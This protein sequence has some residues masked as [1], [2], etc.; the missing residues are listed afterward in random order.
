MEPDLAAE[1]EALADREDEED[2]EEDIDKRWFAKAAPLVDHLNA[3]SK[4]VCRHPGFT[5]A[6]DEQMKK[7]KGRS[8]QTHRM[9]NK[10]IKEGFKF[11]ALCDTGT[12]FVFHSN[13]DGRGE[14]GGTLGDTVK[15]LIKSLPRRGEL[16]H[17]IAM[18]NLFT[19]RQV[20]EQSRQLCVA[21]V[22]AARARRGW[23]PKEIKN[24]TD[25]RFNTLCLLK[26]PSNYLIC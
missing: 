8:S 12:G 18:D 14:R 17:V 15:V 7:F 3:A 6:I 9:K 11:F 2:E 13:P 1:E 10:P 25:D 26:D 16:Q 20:M 23:P 22:G 24:I 19:A 5:C 21:V 4:R